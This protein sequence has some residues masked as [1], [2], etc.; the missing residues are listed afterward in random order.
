MKIL[1]LLPVAFI[2][3]IF[4]V[5]PSP[6]ELNVN[7][8]HMVGIYLAMLYG[9][10]FRPYTD[11]VMMLI[12][13]GFASLFID[14]KVLF[15]G[16]GHPLVWFIISAFIICRAFVI[17]GLGKRIA[18]L[19]LRKYGSNTLTL[20]YMMLFTDAI[21]A[22]AT[23]SNM[24][25]SGGITYPIFRNIAE[26][27]GSS[28]ENNPRKIGAYL[29]M[30]MYIISMGTSSLFMT[31]MATNSIIVSLANEILGIQLEWIQWLKAS[32]VPAGLV[33][34]GAPFI[35]YKLYAPELKKI[36]NV[37]Q[38]AEDGLKSLGAIK[39]EEK[40]L[41]VFFVI[42]VLGWMTGSITGI[43]Y[44]SVGLAFLGALLLFKVLTWD[45]VVGEKAAWQTFVWY[46]AFYGVATALSKGGFY[47]YLVDVIQGYIDLS[48]YS[49]FTSLL[50][51]VLFSLSVRYFF[52][53]NSAFVVSF[54]PVLFTLGMTTS[55][56]PLYIALSLAF[57]A[58]YG[59]LLTHYG[60]GA[61]VI[62]FSSGYVP[63]KTFWTL[64]TIFV[65]INLIAYV[66]I[67]IPYWNLIGM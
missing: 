67:G 64:G 8:W 15:A 9:L 57:S 47:M 16:F 52:V 63:Q 27:L 22:P 26:S 19:L 11:S 34:L 1:N 40:L 48:G 56:E 32:I 17:T 38:I 50:V 2:A 31:G 65:V 49:Q 6:G 61:G 30:L 59:A 23:G 10:V 7:T 29:T 4:W 36:D 53:S 51:L 33:L 3:A 39:R 25:R 18:Y 42:G 21:L 24:S 12:I 13:A 5:I 43:K 62:T 41:I 58:G 54:Y 44:V 66:F 46:G 45:D 37:K 55:A 35:L 14:S 60:N 20:G 28:P